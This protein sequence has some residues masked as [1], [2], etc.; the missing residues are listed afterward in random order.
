MADSPFIVEVTA[1]NFEE[2]VIQGSA[3]HL[4]LVDFWADWC[5]P[6]KMLLPVLSK[7][8][9]EFNG[10]FV[11]AKVNSD[12]QQSL[13]QQY[14]VRS[15][16]TVKFFKN[17]EIVDEFMGA[18]SEGQ[19]RAMLDQHIIRESDH[20][21]QQAMALQSE[22]KTDEAISLLEQANEID[23]GRTVIIADLAGLLLQQGDLE[24]AETLIQSLPDSEKE[25][26]E[27]AS[28]LANLEFAQAADKLPDVSELEK[29][30]AGD[31]NNLQARYQYAML[32]IN[33]GDYETGMQ[34]LLEIMKRD[35][36]FEDDLGRKTLLK[37]F[38]MLG[39]D[40]VA[41]KYR[42]QMFNLLY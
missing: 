27:I 30:M 3:E 21:H 22:G 36:K 24:K 38:D 13:A 34:Q 31:E 20:L 28:L 26:P 35:R 25:K 6:C 14:A 18:Q 23:P 2:V 40:P 39:D 41:A 1:E 10:Q 5:A 12:Q 19:I 37:V 16:P 8:A 11:L 29:T 32:K 7:L 9:D 15:L 42:R 17:G 4:V 33:A